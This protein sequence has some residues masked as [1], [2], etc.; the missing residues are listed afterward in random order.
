MV[1]QASEFKQQVVDIKPVTDKIDKQLRYHGHATFLISELDKYSEYIKNQ[2]IITITKEY[3]N[4]GWHVY[5]PLE[6]VRGDDQREGKS[7]DY[8]SITL[9]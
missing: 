7:W 4:A 9:K 2:I 1:Y 3:T 8:L 5:L 6:R